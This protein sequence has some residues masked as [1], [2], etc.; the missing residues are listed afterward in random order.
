[1]HKIIKIYYAPDETG[2]AQLLGKRH[3]RIIDVPLLNDELLQDDIV[4]LDRHPDD[5]GGYPRIEKVVFTRFPERSQV[6]LGNTEEAMTL[7]AILSILDAECY[8]ILPPRQGELGVMVVGH[9]EDLD[10][11]ALANAIGIKQ[12]DEEIVEPASPES[13]HSRKSKGPVTDDTEAEPTVVSQ[14]SEAPD[15]L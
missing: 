15:E 6:S 5:P 8:V 11:V 3:A 10:P 4:R 14:S 2:P 7:R 9:Y 1:M 13:E 12:T